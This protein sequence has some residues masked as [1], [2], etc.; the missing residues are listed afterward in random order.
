MHHCIYR[1]ATHVYLFPFYKQFIALDEGESRG[2]IV[3][4]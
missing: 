2:L 1:S 3:T 4:S